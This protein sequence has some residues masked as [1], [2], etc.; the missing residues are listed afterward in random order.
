MHPGTAMT[1]ALTR[2]PSTSRL[3]LAGAIALMII[4]VILILP[5]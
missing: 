1:T 4:V 2:V 3:R 5:L